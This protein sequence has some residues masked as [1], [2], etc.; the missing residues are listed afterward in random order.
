MDLAAI[1][2]DKM[3]SSPSFV[4]KGCVKNDIMSYSIYQ[5]QNA[6]G[7]NLAFPAQ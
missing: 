2:I 1:S 6:E 3:T 5:V 7:R 4:C